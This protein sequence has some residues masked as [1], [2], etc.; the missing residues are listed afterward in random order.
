MVGG[1]IS[2]QALT[3]NMGNKPA[4]QDAVNDVFGQLKGSPT[5]LSVSTQEE[6]APN[7]KRLVDLLKEKLEADGS[8]YEI[9]EAYHTTMAGANN[10]KKTL[11]K[12]L[13]TDENRVST[14]VLV[15]KPY[16]L[17]NAQTRIDYQ[18][19]GG[20]KDENK[21]VNKS[22]ITVLGKLTD[23]NNQPIM[24]ISVSGGHFDA[25]QD[26]KRRAH[27]NKY[28]KNSGM[29]TPDA[30]SFDQ[31][32]EE[33]S[34]FRIVTGDFNER[35][36][37]Y[38]LDK[39]IN[40]VDMMKQT[41][42][43]SY[44]FDI[45]KQPKM[46]KGH[47]LL[48]GTYGLKGINDP[49]PKTQRKHVTKGGFLDRVAYTCG[50]KVKEGDHGFKVD[51]THMKANKKGKIFYHG[52]DH[53]PVLRSFEVT[54]PDPNTK[55]ITVANHIKR[56]IPNFQD[57]INHVDFLLKNQDRLM[58]ALDVVPLQHHDSEFSKRQFIRMYAGVSE[59]ADL[60]EVI[61]GLQNKLT[62]LKAAHNEF[63]RMANRVT[64]ASG[65]SPPDTKF[66]E[67][68]FN[69]I[70]NCSDLKNALQEID[71]LP[72]KKMSKEDKLAIKQLAGR[73]V[74]DMYLAAAKRLGGE[75]AAIPVS[76]A[77]SAMLEKYTDL[78]VV[79][80]LSDAKNQATV[81]LQRMELPIVAQ[82]LP[83]SVPPRTSHQNAASA[84]VPM[85]SRTFNPEPSISKQTAH[86][87]HGF[88]QVLTTLYSSKQKGSQV[89]RDDTQP[90]VESGATP[91]KP[92]K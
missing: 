17:Q 61:K 7:G 78:P 30:K 11:F 21:K 57:E 91:V 59:G 51:A 50:L 34:A 8:Q 79:K 65:R 62:T 92:K 26:Q 15:K 10:S 72:E 66:L 3:W 12:A 44:G 23:G 48:K 28:L 71:D 90:K 20:G 85:P 32:Y 87:D 16:H 54:P 67:S 68:V 49:D 19:N 60:P 56:R 70:N 55:A 14:A 76:L 73:L 38:G 81:S 84:A 29:K 36:Q 24:D 4:S 33:A 86:V 9:I 80:R 83:P 42:F 88:R 39:K 13:L 75:K 45:D 25:N 2:I 58:T 52:S 64:L 35:N 69:Q 41:N 43:K 18:S 74:D 63:D 53:L 47:E 5:V 6:L 22:I 37:L 46:M 82:Q 31:I 40:A 89:T 27:A 1:P 77:L